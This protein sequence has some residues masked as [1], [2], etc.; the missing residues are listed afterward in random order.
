MLSFVF[1]FYRRFIVMASIATLLLIWRMGMGNF[2]VVFYTK[3]GVSAGFIA[4]THFTYAREYYYYRNRGVRPSVLW[5]GSLVMDMAIFLLI[6][7]AVRSL[8]L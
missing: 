6:I 1:T 7:M 3:L 5:A 2:A 8:L 4:I